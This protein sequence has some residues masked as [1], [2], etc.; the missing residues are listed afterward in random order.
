MAKIRAIDI[1][2]QETVVEV[3]SD[4]ADALKAFVTEEGQQIVTDEI[5]KEIIELLRKSK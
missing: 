3:D 1:N 2:E 5:N 4:L